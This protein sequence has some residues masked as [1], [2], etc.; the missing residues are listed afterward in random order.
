MPR[1]CVHEGHMVFAVDAHSLLRPAIIYLQ[2]GPDAQWYAGKGLCFL[3]LQCFF[4]DIL[5]WSL[6]FGKEQLADILRWSVQFGK[7]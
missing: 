3:E 7:E 1:S 2:R 6:Q 4:I 5:G